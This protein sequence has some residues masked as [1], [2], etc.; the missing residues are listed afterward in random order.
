[1]DLP[2]LFPTESLI[3]SVESSFG[4][5]MIVRVFS[6]LWYDVRFIIACKHGDIG[7]QLEEYDRQTCTIRGL[8]PIS[9]LVRHMWESICRLYE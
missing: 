4:M 9:V 1:M 7:R 5:C 8:A 6:N 2:R 3:T